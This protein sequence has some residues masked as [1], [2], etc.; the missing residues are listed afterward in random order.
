MDLYARIVKAKLFIDDHYASPLDLDKLSDEAC[1]SKYHF[2]RLFKKA[3]NKTPYQYLSERRI[4]KAKEK[5]RN[6]T[7]PV[8][9]VC[10]EVG[11]ESHTSFSLK[12]KEYTGETPAVF[13]LRA[14]QTAKLLKEQPD[15]FIP[16]C[17]STMFDPENS[18]S[19]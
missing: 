12:F 5:L 18:N 6:E 15:R 7:V 3:Y 9:E 1:F 11:F 2:L 4:E 17:F 14:M 13:R 19:Q 10:E 8:A 16:S